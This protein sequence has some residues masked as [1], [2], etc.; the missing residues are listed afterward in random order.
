MLHLT[1]E[2]TV[3]ST[4]SHYTMLSELCLPRIVCGPPESQH[5]VA[6]VGHQGTSRTVPQGCSC[7]WGPPPAVWPG[8]PRRSHCGVGWGSSGNTVNHNTTVITLIHN[9]ALKS[10]RLGY[11][12]PTWGSLLPS[13]IM[14]QIWEK[15]IQN[16]QA[17]I[18]QIRPLNVGSVF[19]FKLIPYF[20]MMSF[21][22]WILPSSSVYW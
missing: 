15:K 2:G 5:Q 12:R 4:T 17:L 13:S 21:H 22:S 9:S 20:Q 18:L 1:S 16:K 14:C 10:L 19:C 8:T 7:R 6:R 11:G 3:V